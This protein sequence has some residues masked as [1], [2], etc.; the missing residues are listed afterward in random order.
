MYL[1]HVIDSFTLLR[2]FQED[3]KKN[4]I[5]ITFTNIYR[6]RWFFLIIFSVYLFYFKIFHLTVKQ[7]KKKAFQWAKIHG[8]V[9]Y[10]KSISLTLFFFY[11]VYVT[12]LSYLLCIMFIHM[13][14]KVFLAI[15]LRIIFNLASF[16]FSA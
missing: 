3:K 5:F 13:N 4:R 1:W 10:A 8:N 14:N 6:V 11:C 2:V 12:S 9:V 7:K 15:T 16:F